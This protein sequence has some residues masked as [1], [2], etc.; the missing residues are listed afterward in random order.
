MQEFYFKIFSIGTKTKSLNDLK[1]LK[2]STILIAFELYF[3]LFF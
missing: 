2:N 1:P 3:D